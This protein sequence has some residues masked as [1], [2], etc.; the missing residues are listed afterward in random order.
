MMKKM[1]KSKGLVVLLVT[2]VCIVALSL[3][4]AYGVGEKKVGAAE[5]IKLGL[6]LA[7]GVSI[8]YQVVSDNPTEEQMNDTVY[9]M[10]INKERTNTMV[11]PR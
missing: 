3:V 9:N 4:S 6:D 1:S 7:G 8:T 11:F 10:L 2:I 5:N